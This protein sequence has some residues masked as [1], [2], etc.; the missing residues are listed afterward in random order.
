MAKFRD[1]AHK[2]LVS[3]GEARADEMKHMLARAV[4][5][6][7]MNGA[8]ILSSDADPLAKL[9]SAIHDAEWDGLIDVEM[10]ECAKMA[11]AEAEARMD[12]LRAD[13]VTLAPTYVSVEEV[14]P[15]QAD[16]LGAAEESDSDPGSDG[17]E[18]GW[19]LPWESNTADSG[20]AEEF[21]KSY[22][23][24][25]HK[26]TGRMVRGAPLYIKTSGWGGDIWHF[27]FKNS[28]GEWCLSVEED[29][30]SPGYFKS[31]CSAALPTDEGIRF[32]KNPSSVGGILFGDDEFKILGI[33]VRA[34][35][36]ETASQSVRAALKRSDNLES[37]AWEELRDLQDTLKAYEDL[38]DD[39]ASVE[40]ALRRLEHVPSFF[41]L[42]RLEVPT[43]E[44]MGALEFS[45][46]LSAL[47]SIASV[48]KPAERNVQ[49]WGGASEPWRYGDGS[50]IKN[51]ELIAGTW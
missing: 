2:D 15:D 43:E 14:V 9:R 38:T 10:I 17:S 4:L 41:D 7:A 31:N 40:E 6:Q 48:K 3:E 5:Q 1:L 12:K 29:F 37:R 13:F 45:S 35:T 21:D 18:I 42:H 46:D 23:G 30:E 34:E 27:L 36:A 28:S 22:L 39:K 49:Y 19:G 32:G 8:T 20:H 25:Y 16:G 47:C 24:T 50:A 51:A 26:Q 33:A 44:E 11:E